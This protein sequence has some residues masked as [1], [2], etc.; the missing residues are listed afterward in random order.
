M[1]T[2]KEK[3]VK[4]LKNTRINCTEGVCNCDECEFRF[5]GSGSCCENL[6]AD[7]LVK[8]GATIATDTNDKWVSVDEPPKGDN[9]N[10]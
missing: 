1:E 2:V 7:Y 9:S 10:E 6:I 3:L 4:L 5:A 8:H